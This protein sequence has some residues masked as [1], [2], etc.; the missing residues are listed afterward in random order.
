[1]L[2]YAC[3][4]ARLYSFIKLYSFIYII[5]LVEKEK[6]KVSL[7]EGGVKGVRKGVR[8]GVKRGTIGGIKERGCGGEPSEG[9]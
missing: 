1:M 5:I 3:A 8:E 9:D 4:R 7:E 6:R 2:T